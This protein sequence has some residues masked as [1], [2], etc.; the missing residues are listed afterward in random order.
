MEPSPD[1]ASLPSDYHLILESNQELQAKLLAANSTIASLRSLISHDS[2]DENASVRS[3]ALL[4][5]LAQLSRNHT[6]LVSDNKNLRSEIESLLLTQAHVNEDLRVAREKCLKLKGKLVAARGK[7]AVVNAEVQTDSQ[8]D[9]QWMLANL[10]HEVRKLRGQLQ[11][12]ERQIQGH[13]KSHQLA[14]GRIRALEEENMTLKHAAAAR[15]TPVGLL[16][17]LTMLQDENSLLHE[18]LM[19][20]SGQMAQLLARV[21]ELKAKIHAVQAVESDEYRGEALKTVMK[22]MDSV[23]RKVLQDHSIGDHPLERE[24]AELKSRMKEAEK[25]LSESARKEEAR[26]HQVAELQQGTERLQ[27]HV[28]ELVELVEKLKRDNEA[29][30]PP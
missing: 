10:R 18:R 7:R 21:E 6:S 15:P 1:C 30:L 26:T 24:N 17:D 13:E 20:S 29:L 25:L 23:R 19:A 8:S 14:I 2:P 5:E 12:S 11:E 4:A 27:R 28:D 3:D 16:K 22:G 9:P